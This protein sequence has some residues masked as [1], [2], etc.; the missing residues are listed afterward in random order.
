MIRYNSIYVYTS[1]KHNTIVCN[2]A[3]EYM[4]LDIKGKTR[5]EL[6][7]EGWDFKEVDTPF[8]FQ[9]RTKN[10]TV[11]IKIVP[12]TDSEHANAIRRNTKYVIGVYVPTNW[13]P[14][15]NIKIFVD[16]PEFN[17]VLGLISKEKD[18]LVTSSESAS[19]N[20]KS[21]K[22]FTRKTKAVEAY[23]KL[24]KNCTSTVLLSVRVNNKNEFVSDFKVVEV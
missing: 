11:D 7:K 3:N 5:A 14:T 24:K 2:S 21:I 16:V 6:I 15:P 8:G 9:K 19:R 4:F 1:P 13:T 10:A 22:F 12:L 23:N 17:R 20:L 18:L